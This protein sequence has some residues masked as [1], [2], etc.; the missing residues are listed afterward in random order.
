MKRGTE[1]GIAT[2]VLLIVKSIIHEAE[3]KGTGGVQPHNA[4]LK[5]ELLE[6][7]TVKNRASTKKGNLVMSVYSNTTVWEFR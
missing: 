7:V 6:K 3:R 2:R 1:G 4:V 5:G